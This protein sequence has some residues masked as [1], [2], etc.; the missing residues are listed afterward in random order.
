MSNKISKER[1]SIYYVGLGLIVLGV[2]LFLSSFI[3]VAIDMNSSFG[4]PPTFFL[5][6]V[7]GMICII[8]GN[9]LVSI[10]AKGA[11]GSGLILD[12]E[13]AREDLQPFN[14]AKGKMINDVI[15]NIDVV[16]NIK[17]ERADREAKEIIKIKCRQCGALNDE[18]AKFCKSCGKTI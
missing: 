10:G 3:T 16:K 13:K 14:T 4:G 15:E 11:A 5:R 9:V 8:I 2:I 18:D 7:V 6:A 1:K 17:G 12:P